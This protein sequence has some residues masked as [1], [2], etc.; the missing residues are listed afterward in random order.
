[1]SEINVV[2]ADSETLSR[3]GMELLIQEMNFVD[4]VHTCETEEELM[5]AMQV[6]PPNLLII[7]YNQLGYFSKQTIK[8]IKEAYPKQKIL[9]VST[10][11]HQQS[12]LE[13]LEFGIEG[14]VTRQCS[15]DEIQKAIRGVINGEKFFCNKVLDIILNRSFG[16]EEEDCSPTHLTPRETQIT[17]LIA[18]GKTTKVIAD[19]LILSYHTVHT[20]RKNI[21]RKL[22]AHSTSDIVLYS[23]RMGLINSSSENV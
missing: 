17:T 22:D 18:Q 21:M 14:Y 2:L 12:T 9:V 19:E 16:K 11:Q 5:T 1:M 6:A 7:D 13:V 23:I 8:Q 15:E 10:D 3:N 4:A 20:H